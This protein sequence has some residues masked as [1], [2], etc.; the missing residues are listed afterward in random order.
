MAGRGQGA[1]AA[2]RGPSCSGLGLGLP[3]PRAAAPAVAVGL[4]LSARTDTSRAPGTSLNAAIR[5]AH[6]CVRMQAGSTVL[7]SGRYGRVERREPR[8]TEAAEEISEQTDR[9]EG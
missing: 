8:N 5:L 3:P 4:L 2:P 7:V 1:A 9:A 6:V